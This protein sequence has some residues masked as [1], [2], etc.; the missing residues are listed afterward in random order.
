MIRALRLIICFAPVLAFSAPV[1]LESQFEL[2][3]G[4]RIYRAATPEL[5][6][7]SY[8]LALANPPYYSSFRI[9]SHFLMAGREALR[10][11]GKI[12]IVTKRPD[13][14][15]LHMPAWYEELSIRQRKN[16]Y[17]VQGRRPGD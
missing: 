7:G 13:W 16:Y 11:G 14:Y 10:P 17:L 4:F 5:S 1:F 6:A 12:L 9:A 8:D 2:P 3:A 15:Q